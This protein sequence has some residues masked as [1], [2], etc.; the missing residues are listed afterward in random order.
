MANNVE[1][2]FSATDNTGGAISGV[3]GHLQ[4]IFDTAMG[5]LT[6]NVLMKIG[7]GLVDIGKSVVDFGKDSILAAARV[8]EL[9][10]VNAVLAKNAGISQSAV[11][12][13][14]AEVKKMGIEAG[15]SQKVIAEFI[16]ANL[17][18]GSASDIARIAQDAAVISGKNSTEATDDII[19]A[20]TTLNP[21]ILRN[22]GIIV[23][24]Q[25]SY[26]SYAAELG[27]AAGDLTTT[28]KQQ[29]AL[30]A[31][32]EA[33]AGIAG[34]YEAAMKEPGKVLRSFPRYFDDIK[35]AVGES[36]Q[37]AFGDVLLTLADFVKWLGAAVSEGGT[38][39][40]MIDS[41]AAGVAAI[42]PYITGFIGG[43]KNMTGISANFGVFQAG[44]DK[45][46]A[47][48][49][50]YSPMI[51]E[52]AK[53]IYDKVKEFAEYVAANIAPLIVDKFNEFA[54]WMTENAPLIM[55]YLGKVGDT[56]SFLLDVVKVVFD[57]LKPLISGSFTI[58]LDIIKLFMQLVTGNWSGAWN[59]ILDIFKTLGTSL[60]NAIKALLDGIAG[61]F[62]SSLKEIGVMWSNN[63]NMLVEIVGKIVKILLTKV[64][65]FLYVG[66]SF[67]DG[68][69]NGISNSWSSFTSWMTGLAAGLI[70]KIKGAFGVH[71]PS[72]VFAGIGENLM[73][74]LGQGIENGVNVPINAMYSMAGS[75]TG[76]A[77]GSVGGGGGM[78]NV[79]LN[80]A[81][82]FSMADQY[83]LESKLLPFI[84][85]GIR[86]AEAS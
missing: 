14:A 59:T 65:D 70:A 42:I 79:N 49:V 4:G 30:N 55:E 47:W 75:V 57:V 52:F 10:T 82:V 76:A 43:L 67:V 80:Y 73:A 71:S 69:R 40:P 6:S 31:V 78:I 20:I 33:G 46:S 3:K 17:D 45:L 84:R 36:F 32:V 81:P 28:Q 68:I 83:E 25:A 11:E 54:T 23:D 16:K 37:D 18:L 15:V 44:F 22:A 48:W 72:S 38:L 85:R 74:G 21:L 64:I 77:V 8:E 7:S 39:R 86:E 1:I 66:K 41:L 63:W 60:W 56:F 62:G 34:T 24:L 5:F 35:V 51:Q 27:I 12:A 61:F 50:T 2:V 19:Y 13:E 26:K 29:A 53:G 9:K 58:I